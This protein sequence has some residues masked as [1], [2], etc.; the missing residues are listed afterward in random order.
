LNEAEIDDLIEHEANN[1]RWTLV[2]AIGRDPNVLPR[3]TPEYEKLFEHF[4]A[5]NTAGVVEEAECE[6][7]KRKVIPKR[8]KPG[9]V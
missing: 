3:R 7:A 4:L 6:I 8:R 2:Q 1:V 5:A 9:S